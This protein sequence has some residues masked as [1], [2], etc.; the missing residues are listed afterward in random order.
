MTLTA[1]PQPAPRTRALL[2]CLLLVLAYLLLGPLSL[3]F[4]SG[5]SPVASTVFMPEGVAL[6]FVILYGPRVAAGVFVG[7]L[8]L[9]LGL[10]QPFAVATTIALTSTAAALFGGWVFRR[11]GFS[12]ALQRPNDVAGLFLVMVLSQLVNASGSVLGLA[13]GGGIAP[14]AAGM[15]WLYWLIGNGMGQLLVTPLLLVWLTPGA[16][17][18]RGGFADLAVSTAGVLLLLSCAAGLVQM[19]PL[20]LLAC[21]YPPLAWTALHR[22]VRGATVVNLCMALA[23]I[24]AG[25]G[26]N[27][28][29]EGMAGGK[30]EDPIA[31]VSF[32]IASGCVMSL[33]LSA[34]LSERHALIRELT[35]LTRSD[36]LVNLSNRRHFFDCA[37]RAA[38]AARASGRPLAVLVLDI[39]HFKQINDRHGHAEGDRALKCIAR[40]FAQIARENDLAARLG[41]EEFA[42]LL[43]DIDLAQARRIAEHLRSMIAA[44]ECR[45]ARGDV[46]RMT[47]SIGLACFEADEDI[48]DTMVRADRALYRAKRAGRNRVDEQPRAVQ[49]AATASASSA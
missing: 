36:P 26:G 42:M 6:A 48:D 44:H 17:R 49:S 22:G 32:F 29:F 11:C 10:Q 35:G 28:F 47:A 40:C 43:P 24:W 15:T 37:E 27:G 9:C 39:D 7:Q 2:P 19:H 3:A 21:A 20:V 45:T 18:Q 5:H 25:S 12:S 31:Y 46:L 38:E 14:S 1:T 41:G 23:V 13:F 33:L 34:L 30:S 8:L 16:I 4:A